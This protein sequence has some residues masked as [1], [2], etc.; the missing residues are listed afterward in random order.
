MP[1]T[2]DVVS[3]RKIFKTAAESLAGQTVRKQLGS[4]SR[5]KSGGRVIP[6][7]SAKQT[8]SSRV[9]IFTKFFQFSCRVSFGTNFFQ[10]QLTRSLLLEKLFE[11]DNVFLQQVIIRILLI[12]Y[13]TSVHFSLTMFHFYPKR[14]LPF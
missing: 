13:D 5:K 11:V 2:A 6:T 10:L 1:E 3:S 4:G 8:N 7:K 14:L 9:H 12:K